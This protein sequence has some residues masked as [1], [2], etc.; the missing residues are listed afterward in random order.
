MKRLFAGIAVCIGTVLGTAAMVPSASQVPASLRDI[1]AVEFYALG[2]DR[3][4]INDLKAEEVTIKMDGRTRKVSSLQLVTVAPEPP[5]DAAT[6]A[7]ETAPAPFSTNTAAEAGRTFIMVLDDESFRPGRERPLRGAVS[8]FLGALAPRDRVS[9]ITVPHGGMKANLTS[10]HDRVM[11]ELNQLI[12]HAPET[13]SAQDG[14][15]RTRDVL[16][17]LEGMLNSLAGGEGPTTIMFI[18]ATEYGPRRDAPSTLAPGRCELTTQVFERMGNAAAQARAHFWVIQPEQIMNRGSIASETIGGA[19]FSGSENPLEGLEH[20]AGV[21]SAER[22]SLSTAGDETLVQIARETTAYYSAVI[23]TTVADLDGIT[24][25]IDVK[26]GRAGVRVRARPKLYLPKPAGARPVAKTPPEM[27]KD[28]REFHDLPLRAAGF[29]SLAGADGTMKVIAVSEPV[30]PS[31]KITALTAALFDGQGRLTRQ[32]TATPDQ[33]TGAPHMTALLVPPGQYRLR[34]AAVDAAGRGGT[35]DAEVS[36]ETTPAGPLK[37]SSLVVGLSRN[38]SFVPRLQFGNE[39]VAIGFLE[40][41]GGAAGQGIGAAVEVAKTLDG[42]PLVVTR[43]AIEAASEPGLFR[44]TGAVPIGALPP[45]DYV[46][47]ALVALQD[48]PYG[49]VVR[50]IRKVGQ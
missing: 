15:C 44:A 25:G 12:G 7:A 18:S 30:D 48:Q 20:I 36:A 40:I 38:G 45:G 46:V 10:N 1:V 41:Y 43:L 22:L 27:I 42:P 34:V 39:P 17:S 33:L 13:E 37:L 16:Q 8:R 2:S 31:T 29:A 24:R 9:L 5:S 19:G 3:R 28:S 35:T 32:V 49:R 21:T 14:A 26:V 47:R 6:P 50:T 4:P 23:D 11:N